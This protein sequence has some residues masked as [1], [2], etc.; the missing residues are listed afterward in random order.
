MGFGDGKCKHSDPPGMAS[1]SGAASNANK[2]A[3]AVLPQLQKNESASSVV[4]KYMDG[5]TKRIG[6]LTDSCYT[7]N[8]QTLVQLFLLKQKAWKNNKKISLK[9]NMFFF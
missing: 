8:I 4:L 3:P 2:T 6:K 7:S 1:N 9:K 5:I